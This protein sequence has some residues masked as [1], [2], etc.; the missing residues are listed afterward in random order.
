LDQVRELALRTCEQRALLGRGGLGGGALRVDRRGHPLGLLLGRLE[1]GDLELDVLARRFEAVEQLL[2]VAGGRAQVAL[3][4]ADVGAIALKQHGQRAAV[5][6][7][8]VG[9]HRVGS[10][11]LL[12]L[13]HL[14]LGG[15]DLRLRGR[16]L[17]L[18]L[19]QLVLRLVELLGQDLDPLVEVV[20][21]RGDALGLGALV[22]DLV[23]R[24]G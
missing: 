16:F 14:G 19:G 2:A 21:L 9:L 23:T 15:I 24:C 4:L 7:S 18:D 22:A 6:A 13:G 3:A 10:Q 17:R 1:L 12:A 11:L 8:H 5:A 20:D